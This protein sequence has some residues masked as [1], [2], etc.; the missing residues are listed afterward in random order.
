MTD[1]TTWLFDWINKRAPNVVLGLTDN[2][3]DLGAIDSLGVI[4]LIEDMEQTF[5]V[6]FT[7][8]D[9]QDRRFLYISGLVEMLTE[10]NTNEVSLFR[11]KS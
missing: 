9:F 8:E 1:F 6:R 11:G 3:F 2:Y 10:K 7:Q 4:E 5:Q